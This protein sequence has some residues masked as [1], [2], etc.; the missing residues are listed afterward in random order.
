LSVAQVRTL[1]T[2]AESGVSLESG[3][4]LARD[5]V[6]WLRILVEPVGVRV[7]VLRATLRIE[8][9]EL[10]RLP[11]LPRSWDFKPGI[12]RERTEARREWTEIGSESVPPDP[13]IKDERMVRDRCGFRIM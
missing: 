2:L 11:F 12:V 3:L 1:V 7:A 5:V 13:R 4:S 6:L 10:A 9:P 8:L